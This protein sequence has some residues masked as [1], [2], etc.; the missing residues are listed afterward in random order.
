MIKSNVIELS[1]DHSEPIVNAKSRSNVPDSHTFS[2]PLLD[3]D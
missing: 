2:S 3:L 1:W